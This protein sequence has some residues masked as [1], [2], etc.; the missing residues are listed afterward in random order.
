MGGMELHDGT[1]R[2]RVDR[3]SRKGVDTDPIPSASDLVCIRSIPETLREAIFLSRLGGL[4][5]ITLGSGHTKT[6]SIVGIQLV[7]DHF[8][9]PLH[10]NYR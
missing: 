10:L 7:L 1:G 3:F 6:R 5:S 2:V 9:L 8:K 4:V